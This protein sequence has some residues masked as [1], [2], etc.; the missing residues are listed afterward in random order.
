MP[1]EQFDIIYADLVRTARRV[2]LKGGEKTEE[3]ERMKK[4]E[5]QNRRTVKNRADGNE[6]GGSEEDA[7]ENTE[8]SGKEE[9]GAEEN[10]VSLESQ[11]KTTEKAG[12]KN[13]K[14]E[15]L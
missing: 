10:L 7:E 12:K 1:R 14:T 11:S 3:E 13:E 4:G 9:S 6:G 8:E 15:T 5:V 2:V